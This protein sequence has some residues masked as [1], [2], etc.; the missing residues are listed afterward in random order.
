MIFTSCICEEPIT[1][2]WESG[3]KQ[4]YYRN[5]CEKC[6]KIAMV[7][8]TSLGGETYFFDNEEELEKFIDE[9]SLNKPLPTNLP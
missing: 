2:A 3:M 9:K 6:G 1:V 7:E 8:L 4:G 5:N